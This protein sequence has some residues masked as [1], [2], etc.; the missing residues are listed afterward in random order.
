MQLRSTRQSRDRQAKGAFVSSLEMTKDILPIEPSLRGDTF[1]STSLWLADAY[2]EAAEVLCNAMAEDQFQREY[3]QSRVILQ[4][5]RH[6]LELF[7]KGAIASKPG[8]KLQRTHRLDLL[9]AEYEALFPSEK[10]AIDPPFP[11]EVL[12]DALTNLFPDS[13]EA[14][15][16]SHDQR[17]R[18]PSDVGGVPFS[19]HEPFDVVAQLEAI[20]KFRGQ[21]NWMV[22]RIDF[23]WWN[24]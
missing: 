10:H 4:L 3:T 12:H 1:S 20:K 14:Y 19:E 5:C 2:A 15:Q 13:L 24:F 18:Y 8:T 23:N 9:Y 22:A 16:K 11:P 21:I 6:A 7:L 17:F